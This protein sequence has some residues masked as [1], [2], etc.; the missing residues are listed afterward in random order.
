MSGSR[1]RPYFGP[2]TARSSLTGRVS[3][4]YASP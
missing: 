1:P 2:L 3:S 4:S